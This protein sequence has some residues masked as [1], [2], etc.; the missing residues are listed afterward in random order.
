M[1]VHLGHELS[2][3]LDGEL[4][5]AEARKVA[6]HLGGCES[7][8]GELNEL[9]EIRARL[10]SLPMMDY[11]WQAVERPVVVPL[12]RRARVIIGTAAAAAAAIIA[13]ATVSAPRE[14]IAL[15]PSDFSPSFVAR[16]TLDQNFTGRLIPPD[17]LTASAED[18]G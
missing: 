15:S 18:N 6:G 7:C 14:V 13:V 9:I 2:A 4:Q 11:V 10:R 3:Y 12:V 17:V 5:A 8:R 1:K 16:Q